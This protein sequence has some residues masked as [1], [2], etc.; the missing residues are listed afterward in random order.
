MGRQGLYAD[1]VVYDIL[2][3]SG[4][5]GEVGAF[6]ELEMQFAPGK[7]L[8]DSLWF[9]PAC[10]TGRY[11]RDLQKRKKRVAGFDLHEGQL[12]Y[13][14]GRLDVPPGALFQADMADFSA[15]AH[16]AGLEP[17]SVD[18]A[19]NPV[20]SIRH[21]DSDQA[22][23]KHFEQMADFMKPGAVYLVGLSLTDYENLMPEEDLWR[24]GRGH[25]KVSQ[26]VNY[27]PPEPGTSK[28]R[29]EQVISHLTVEG[30]NR[31]EHFDDTYDL[32]TYDTK[33]WRDL[34]GKSRLDH[35]GSFDAFARPLDGRVLAYQ[36]EVL[37]K[38]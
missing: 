26:L 13:A 8:K 32:R 37:R 18:F 34:I 20:N 38:P 6:I 36:L 1:P 30:P 7:I 10:G 23:L 21:L 33:Q 29:V 28:G 2:Y 19:F 24:T 4:T 14:R 25:L 15:A 5:A 17:D 16:K 22:M 3:W 31:T 9:E 12:D 27:L 35:V 11:L